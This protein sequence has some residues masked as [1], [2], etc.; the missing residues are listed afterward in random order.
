MKEHNPLALYFDL[1]V[2]LHRLKEPIETRYVRV[3]VPEDE[4]YAT[5]ELRGDIIH[6]LASGIAS[7]REVAQMIHRVARPHLLGPP[8][9]EFLIHLAEGLEGAVTILANIVMSEMCVAGEED[10]HGFSIFT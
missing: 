2:R 3:V 10:A 7:V 5:V 6:V 4:V 1:V 9:D 8:P